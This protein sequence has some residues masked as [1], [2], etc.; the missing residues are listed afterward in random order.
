MQ[1]TIA[2]R[3]CTRVRARRSR[4]GY[5]DIVWRDMLSGTYENPKEWTHTCGFDDA[6]EQQLLRMLAYGDVHQE[7]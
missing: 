6:K 5:G 3:P 1:P 4:E 7:T 2:E